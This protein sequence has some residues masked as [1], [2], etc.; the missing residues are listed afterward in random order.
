V[1]AV[2]RDVFAPVDG[3]ISE[4]LVAHGDTVTAGQELL[5][6]RRPQLD[7][8]RTRV[9]GELQTARKRQSSLQALRFAGNATTAEAREQYRQRTADEEEIKEQLTSL[10]EQ[11]ELLDQ[12]QAELT[13]RSPIAG[14][15]LTW[16]VAQ[17]LASRPI[18]RG[19]M[20]LSIGDP[21][22][23]WELDLRV[24]D[25][26]VGHLLDARRNS[27]HPLPVS[28]LLAMDPDHECTAQLSDVAL[29]T[30]LLENDRP[31]VLVT[32]TV[33]REALPRLRPGASVLAKI[34][35]GRRSLGFVWLHDLWDALRTRLFF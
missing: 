18:E 35:C 7:L 21:S 5:R 11:L 23:P 8:E 22:G 12:Q 27:D 10:Q 26:R 24:D 29:N 33:D 4:I 16:D 17:V 20:L 2:R 13:V 25:D 1:P 15:V 9:L 3:V 34:H 6:L 28:F 32:A 19:Q 14:Q 31:Q 30:D